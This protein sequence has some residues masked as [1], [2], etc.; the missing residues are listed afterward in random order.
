MA[1]TATSLSTPGRHLRCAT[2]AC[3]STVPVFTIDETAKTA[4]FVISSDYA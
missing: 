4:T 2:A 1:T 3:Y